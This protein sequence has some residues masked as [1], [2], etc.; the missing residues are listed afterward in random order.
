MKSFF[1]KNKLFDDFMLKVYGDYQFSQ[2]DKK[3][4]FYSYDKW[5]SESDAW[6]LYYDLVA[7]EVVLHKE[8][9]RMSLSK[10][11][12]RINNMKVFL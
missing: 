11:E 4:I 2:I 9:T 3:L 6:F 10:F 7:N 5:I 1:L 12:E 8:N